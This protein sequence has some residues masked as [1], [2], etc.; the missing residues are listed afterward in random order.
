MRI[1]LNADLGEGA[2]HDEAM[3]ES[4]SSIN[5]ACAWHAGSAEQMLSLVRAARERGVAIGAHPSFPDRAN[6]GRQEMTL[7]L[8]S[9]RA[10]LL[11]QM[12]ALDGIVR[13]EGG[14]L[15]HVKAH[16]A[17]YNQA[18]RDPELARCIAQAIRDFNPRLKVVGLAGSLFIEAARAA[19]L[20]AL[21]EGF[22]D[23]RYGAAGHLLK[24][25]TPGALIDDENSML[26]QVLSMVKTGSVVAQDGTVLHVHVDTICLHGDGPHALEFA[27]AIRAQLRHEG[28]EVAP[29]A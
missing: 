17:L 16:G 11:Y 22:A 10:G 8:S 12:G 2:P 5:V 6:F 19:G 18:A 28:I 21:E 4:V 9:V 1:D 29:C 3:L 25:G 14:Q 13:A 20:Q 26:A 24:R 7:P 27:R 23:R 15:A